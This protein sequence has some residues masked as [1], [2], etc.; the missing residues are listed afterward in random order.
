MRYSRTELALLVAGFRA[1]SRGIPCNA[2]F[3][4]DPPPLN[5]PDQDYNDSD[6]Q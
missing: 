3:L 6:D 2:D 5:N 1:G 4:K